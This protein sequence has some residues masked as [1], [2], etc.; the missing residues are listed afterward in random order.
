M[1]FDERFTAI[2][3]HV[4]RRHQADWTE[5]ERHLDQLQAEVAELLRRVPAPDHVPASVTVTIH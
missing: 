4:N 5:L 3:G 2:R 1:D